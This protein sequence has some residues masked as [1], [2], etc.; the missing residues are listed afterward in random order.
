MK[1][2]KHYIA[3]DGSQFFTEE[4]CRFY[5]QH[6]LKVRVEEVAC[7]Y[8]NGTGLTTFLGGWESDQSPERVTEECRICA[9][10]GKLHKRID[11]IQFGS[12]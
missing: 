3:K 9:G 2:V 8:C 6:Y 11:N 5:E 1:E 4:A 7:K 12:D 10:T